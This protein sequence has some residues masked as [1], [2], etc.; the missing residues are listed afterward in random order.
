MPATDLTL[1]DVVQV[2]GPS[3]S[4]VG[5]L[6]KRVV[7]CSVPPFHMGFFGPCCWKKS[8]GYFFG[9]PPNN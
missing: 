8:T 3:V 2:P 5:A 7:G 9:H 4:V 6:F 1:G